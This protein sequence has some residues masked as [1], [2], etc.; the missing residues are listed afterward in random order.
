MLIHNIEYLNDI[1]KINPKIPA[2]LKES[3]EQT[4]AKYKDF[5]SQYQS[6]SKDNSPE[7]DKIKQLKLL[8]R[9]LLQTPFEFGWNWAKKNNQT[10]S[11]LQPFRDIAPPY[12]LSDLEPVES[13]LKKSPEEY[14]MLKCM[15][16]LNIE[17]NRKPPNPQEVVKLMQNLQKILYENLEGK[18]LKAMVPTSNMKL[19]TLIENAKNI[20][21]TKNEQNKSKKKYLEDSIREL[22]NTDPITVRTMVTRLNALNAVDEM[23]NFCKLIQQQLN[24]PSDTK[25]WEA[26]QIQYRHRKKSTETKEPMEDAPVILHT[27]VPEDTKMSTEES[28]AYVQRLQAAREAADYAAQRAE[29]ATHFAKQADEAAKR[30]ERAAERAAN[31]LLPKGQRKAPPPPPKK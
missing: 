15:S 7:E 26:R 25:T 22:N 23:I 3:I 21:N 2:N 4:K 1:L 27:A 13:S 31:S 30:A 29:G 8:N 12:R 17:T 11:A 16:K 6:L 20:L 9:R 18:S 14:A 24:D 19:E 5:L 28:E 10:N